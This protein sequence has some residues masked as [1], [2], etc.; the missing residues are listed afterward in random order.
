MLKKI[1]S[2]LLL[3]LGLLL[4]TMY[5]LL[6][7]VWLFLNYFLI[8]LGAKIVS[9]FSKN[10]PLIW[11]GGFTGFMAATGGWVLYGV[12]DHHLIQN[13]ITR[14]C[15]ARAGL[16]IYITPEEYGR[17]MREPGYEELSLKEDLYRKTGERITLKRDLIVDG[18]LY[19]KWS[20]LYDKGGNLFNMSGDGAGGK[21]ADPFFSTYMVIDLKTNTKLATVIWV[22]VGGSISYLAT[23]NFSG[24]KVWKHDFKNCPFATYYSKDYHNIIEEYKSQIINIEK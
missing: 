8:K 11:L 24:F 12:I 7:I 10:K 18:M 22:D 15:E 4:L 13:R 17:M 20:R 19:R 6:F 1:Q 21:Y 16:H 2:R 5:T 23:G 14:L 3:L 9:S